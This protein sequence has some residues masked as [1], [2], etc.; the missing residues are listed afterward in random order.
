MYVYVNGDKPRTIKVKSR[1]HGMKLTVA[2]YK[3]IHGLAWV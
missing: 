1:L 3:A 2:M